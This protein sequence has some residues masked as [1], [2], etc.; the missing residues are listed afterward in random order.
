[1]ADAVDLKT[2]VCESGMS[3]DIS[4]YIKMRTS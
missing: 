1:M 2:N 4:V 3:R